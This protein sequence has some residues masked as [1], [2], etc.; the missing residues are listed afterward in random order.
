[1]IAKCLVLALSVVASVN[2]LA[3]PHA[4]RHTLHHRSL[5][6]RVA[7]PRSEN[8][9]P[10][11]NVAAR[12]PGTGRKRCR[13]RPT[14]SSSLVSSTA[15]PSITPPIN[16]APIPSSTVDE[17]KPTTT[18]TPPPKPTTTTTKAAPAPTTTP[19]PST[20]STKAPAPTSGGGS[21]G[22]PGGFLAG[23]NTGQATYY[24]AGL[25]ACGKVNGAN[26]NIVAVS[27]RLFDTYP[28]YN[29][30]NP[31]NNPVC[32]K[33]IRA[34]KDG[35]ELIVEVVDRCE[36]CAITDLDFTN[37]GFDRLTGNRREL[38]RTS[39]QWEWA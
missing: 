27:R 1:M 34:W 23:T 39:F 6:A 37:G 18:S 19:K 2:A 30:A 35:K 20:T 8:V 17:P 29:G 12:A 16:A 25:G 38:G 36:A 33:K 14:A 32:G 28:G 7:E 31:N 13:T 15:A 11:A 22:A 24:D 3:T 4:A 10:F 21:G 5:A 26:D 9:A